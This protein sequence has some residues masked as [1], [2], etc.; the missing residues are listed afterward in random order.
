MLTAIYWIQ[1]RVPNEGATEHIQ[2]VEAV[3]SSIGRI[4]I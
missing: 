3:Y 2:G 4:T 1:H